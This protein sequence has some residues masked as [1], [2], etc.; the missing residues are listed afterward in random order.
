MPRKKYDTFLLT[1]PSEIAEDTEMEMI[2]RD[3]SPEDRRYKYEGTYVN[4]KISKDPDKYPDE[5]E[6]RLGRGQLFEE[7]WSIEISNFFNKFDD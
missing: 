6:I 5:L 4:A 7:T 3:L 1:E 2:V